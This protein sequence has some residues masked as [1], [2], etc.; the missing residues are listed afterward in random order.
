MAPPAG[1]HTYRITMDAKLDTISQ[2]NEAAAFVNVQGPPNVL[3]IEGK[4]GAGS[5]IAAALR[6][7]QINVTIGT[8]A[9]V[10]IALQGLVNFDAV[11]LADVPAADLGP[12][13]MH[14]L[15]SFVRDLWPGLV[16]SGGEDS[17]SIGGHC[18]NPLEEKRAVRMEVAHAQA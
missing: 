2:N 18:N 5:N 16:V 4:P 14:V 6:A 1:F 15:Q 13:R 12:T 11:V 9:D 3:V 7:T 10:P 8:P 17:Y